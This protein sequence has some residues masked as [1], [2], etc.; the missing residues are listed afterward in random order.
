MHYVVDPCKESVQI[1]WC[2]EGAFIFS[3]IDGLVISSLLHRNP[4]RK[5]RLATAL[6]GD[7]SEKQKSQRV[8]CI[9]VGILHRKC[10]VSRGM[11]H[12]DFFFVEYS[13]F[14]ELLILN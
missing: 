9:S 4:C 6:S 7:L 13:F 8:L 5:W 12:S 14:G 2:L 10:A 1:P 11:K 3:L